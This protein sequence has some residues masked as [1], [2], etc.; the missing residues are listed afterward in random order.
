M[1]CLWTLSG[2][3]IDWCCTFNLKS[4]V[5]SF[6]AVAG[7]WAKEHKIGG[8]KGAVWLYVGAPVCLLALCLLLP[9]L[10][11]WDPEY[12]TVLF[13]CCYF[14]LLLF[15]SHKAGKSNSCFIISLF[16]G[17]NIA[18]GREGETER[19][20]ILL[21]KVWREMLLLSLSRASIYSENR[22]HVL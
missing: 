4:F 16:E 10:N 5:L 22:F 11:R 18:K 15:A 1:T 19:L 7:Y 13:P 6:A 8:V 2:Y 12:I 17:R 21:A 20:V 3:Q 9:V 14:W